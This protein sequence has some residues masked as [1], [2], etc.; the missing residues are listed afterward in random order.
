MTH[1]TLHKRVLNM[2]GIGLPAPAVPPLNFEQFSLRSRVLSM[3]LG[4]NL[5]APEDRATAAQPVPS[6]ESTSAES[7][8]ELPASSEA[9]TPVAPE[10][11]RRRGRHAEEAGDPTTALDLYWRAMRLDSAPVLHDLAR[12][13]LSLSGRPEVVKA[14]WDRLRLASPEEYPDQDPGMMPVIV[15]ERLEA[16]E[17]YEEAGQL[18]AA[19]FDS[20]VQVYG[21]GEV[22]GMLLASHRALAVQLL[23]EAAIEDQ[24]YQAITNLAHLVSID[25]TARQPLLPILE[26]LAPTHSDALVEIAQWLLAGPDASAPPEEIATPMANKILRIA[27][28]VG[29]EQAIAMLR[30]SR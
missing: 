24:N 6:P 17:S 2:L 7:A 21:K 4:V 29:N 8:Q 20:A 9:D 26:Q 10:Q 5:L 1:E 11:L 28:E 16:G 23:I 25:R 3:L 22:G 30:P 13:L 15:A 27:A 19:F 18:R 14:V 12:L